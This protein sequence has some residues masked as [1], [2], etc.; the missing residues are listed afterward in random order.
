LQKESGKKKEEKLYIKTKLRGTQIER[1]SIS[2]INQAEKKGGKENRSS[3][4]GNFRGRQKR[5]KKSF[6]PS[7][8]RPQRCKR[9]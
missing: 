5:K 6:Q 7:M 3:C 4:P 8:K 9:V 2:T 1:H